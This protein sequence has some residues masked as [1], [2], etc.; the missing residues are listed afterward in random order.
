ME[1]VMNDKITHILKILNKPWG[2]MVDFVNDNF[3]LI[4]YANN[5]AL[6][7]AQREN[8]TLEEAEL[9]TTL[10]EF[11]N[12]LFHKDADY[13]IYQKLALSLKLLLENQSSVLTPLLKA[14]AYLDSVYADY[15][16]TDDQT[17]LDFESK[18][19]ESLAFL[20]S[21]EAFVNE[22]LLSYINIS[23][24]YLFQ[25]KSDDTLSYLEKAKLL[26][27]K[28][29]ISNYKALFWYH[30]SWLFVENGDY[31]QASLNI[32]SFFNE[33]GKNDVSPGIYLHAINIRASIEFRLGHKLEAFEF[34]KECYDMALK[35]YETENK[36]VI[37]E[38]LV[39]IGRYYKEMSQLDEAE[40]YIK[41]AIQA[42]SIIFG[43]NALDPS[44]AVAYRI[45]G[46]IYMQ[47]EQYL[48]AKEQFFLAERIFKK[49]YKENFENMHEVKLLMDDLKVLATNNLQ[50]K[51]RIF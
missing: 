6:Y 43:S 47:K 28:V 37:A 21:N 13:N 34:A 36:D 3:E 42:F 50:K 23:Q 7:S 22:R 4:D 39:T 29:V 33:Y 15:I 48:Q 38:N 40:N 45:L 2:Q 51:D 35:F 30:Y 49:L 16:F 5:L 12:I 17:K 19:H 10:L 41:R 46:E 14:R 32:E 18:L 31:E 24:F 1:S 44:Q 25:G 11:N 26:L 9:L 8:Y 27:P 20:E